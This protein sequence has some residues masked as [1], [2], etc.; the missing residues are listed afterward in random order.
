MRNLISLFNLIFMIFSHFYFFHS[1]R[2]DRKEGDGAAQT[3]W[4]N[5]NAQPFSKLGARSTNQVTDW[6]WRCCLVSYGMQ[7]PASWERNQ[8]RFGQS[9]ACNSRIPRLCREN[10]ITLTWTI[11]INNNM[12]LALKTAFCTNCSLSN[13]CLFLVP[14]TFSRN[15]WPES[16]H[17]FLQTLWA[18]FTLR[19]Y[20]LII[21]YYHL[22]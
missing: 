4:A 9:V 13:S 17:W 21:S 14:S 2:H 5:L 11:N 15:P 19:Y 18:H 8:T 10:V 6:S 12:D 3:G 1:W 20:H 16:E 22:F 7:T